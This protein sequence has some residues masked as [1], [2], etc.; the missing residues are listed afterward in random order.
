MA[1]CF[2]CKFLREEDFTASCH[3]EPP[4]HKTFNYKSA[5]FSWQIHKDFTSQQNCFPGHIGQSLGATYLSPLHQNTFGSNFFW[6]GGG[7]M[8]LDANLSKTG[9]IKCIMMKMHALTGALVPYLVCTSGAD[10]D[11]D[12]HFHATLYH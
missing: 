11:I 6:G 7:S 12:I 4:C 5:L 3:C 2:C 1:D 9:R 8:Y 10:A